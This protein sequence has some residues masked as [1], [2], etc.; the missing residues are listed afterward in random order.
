MLLELYS[1]LIKTLPSKGTYSP[2][3]HLIKVDLPALGLPANATNPNVTWMSDKKD[4]ATVENGTVK[5]VAA[6]TAVI[7]VTTEDGGKTATCT[8]TVKEKTSGSEGEGGSSG[9]NGQQTPAITMNGTAYETI[10]A[11]IAEI[12]TSGDTGTYTI[13]LAKG[14]YNENALEYNGSATIKISGDTTTKYGADVIIKGHGSDMTT[15]KTRNL[16]GIQG[17]GDI[18]LENLTLESDWSRA[19][20]AGDVQ[21]EV[22]GTDTKGN[23]IAYNCAF[24]SHQD[25]LRTAG[26]AWFYGCYIE[27]DVDFIWMEQAGSV[28]LYEK[29]EIVSVYDANAS[30]HNT[31]LTAPR[32]TISSKAGKGLVIFNS[33]VKESEEAAANGQLTYLARTPWNSGY[34]N[35]V[36]F[37]NT[38]CTGVETSPWYKS[39]IATDYAK[40]VIGW[41]MDKTTADSIGYAGND[42]I[43]DA[44][45]VS[46]E[47]NGRKSILNRVYNTGKGK[48]EKDTV[49]NWD[50]D[51]V[52]AAN[53]WTVDEDTSSDVLEGESTVEPTIY[54]F[55]G[56]VDQS[57]IC[58]GFALET[59]K[60]HY[61]GAD[62]NT[63][64]IPVT[65][66][67]Y[68]E[69]YGYYTGTAEVKADT[70]GEAVMFFNNGTTGSE[71]SD[72]YIVYDE[73]ATSVVITAKA[74]TYI[75]KVIVTP[76]A[77]IAQRPVTAIE[78]SRS[79]KLDCVGV[80]LTLKAAI[81][82][83]DAT[84]KS[85]KWSSSDENVGKIDTYTGK[86]T[87]VA[88]G[89][90]T[91][92]ATACDGS[93]V[94]ETID[95]SPIAPT[96]TECEWYTT[97]QTLDTEDGAEG[98]GNFNPNGSAYKALTNEET[99]T[100]L[101]G[102]PF[103]TKCGLKLNGSGKLT[104]ATTKSNATLT[105]VI[106]P[107]NKTTEAP[108]VTDGTNTPEASA[109]VTQGNLTIYTYKLAV[110][111][112]YDITRAGTS[113]V[114]PILYA[115]CEYPTAIAETTGFNFKGGSYSGTNLKNVNSDDTIRLDGTKTTYE[116][117]T[118][119]GVKSNGADNWGST[120]AGSTAK[121]K[122]AG[123]C[124]L[125]LY[126][127]KGQT[128]GATVT[129]GSEAP[130][131]LTDAESPSEKTKYSVDIPSACEVTITFGGGYIG[132]F[133]VVYA[134]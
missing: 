7:T 98:I 133:E 36:A 103:S 28:A 48:Y 10:K 126:F 75:T 84:N 76:D 85:V 65:G 112:T 82:P 129:C 87:F 54:K 18:I 130:V 4:V 83:S 47:F 12:P 30:T 38:P 74:A 17:T 60:T 64:T 68:V 59:G 40:T 26:K 92:T 81:T 11:A 105:L 33:T 104:I 25:T 3:I 78:I 50:I 43:V 101:A 46:K 21:A 44:D 115:K 86:V 2:K 15:L 124:K 55:D 49:N 24:K 42:D 89:N 102:T 23:T 71:L 70:Q 13:K 58:T 35:Q 79:G 56:S 20:H 41:K 9:G 32:M 109:P 88:A 52:I 125:N 73:N 80:G 29:C 122:V 94:T 31:Y 120:A 53:N 27:G 22:L 8:V 97:D 107:A 99:Y 127:Y 90:V 93:I 63:I 114:N 121:F 72:T 117:V 51:A 67:S 45:T 61:K 118:F 131:T 69:V 128:K 134:N 116:L 123:A 16:I 34:Y 91:F 57:A 6:G 96:W 66:K 1:S 132:M 111:G 110:A 62:G 14:T 106:A 100:N 5:A 95:C 108:K 39:Q 113:E 37:I 119:E 77:S 19:D